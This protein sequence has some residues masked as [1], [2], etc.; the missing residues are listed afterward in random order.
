MSES[1]KS[2]DFP[3]ITVDPRPAKAQ[4]VYVGSGSSSAVLPIAAP[5]SDKREVW[6]GKVLDLAKHAM[7]EHRQGGFGS[8]D[9]TP[10]QRAFEWAVANYKKLSGGSF[11]VKSLAQSWYQWE[12]RPRKR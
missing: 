1:E 5:P 11:S 12:N 10:R 7:N 3:P 6:P 8:P 9:T 2:R 4:V